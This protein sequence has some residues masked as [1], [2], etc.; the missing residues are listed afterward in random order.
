MCRVDDPCDL[1]V[2]AG[3]VRAHNSR[4]LNVSVIVTVLG[5]VGAPLAHLDL[6][7]GWGGDAR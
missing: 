1:A 6:R 7:E 3:R 2:R 5:L 4:N